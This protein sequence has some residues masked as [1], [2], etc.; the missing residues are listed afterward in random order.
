MRSQR[1]LRMLMYACAIKDAHKVAMNVRTKGLRGA[2]FS[3]L[4]K[5]EQHKMEK[6]C[7]IKTFPMGKLCRSYYIFVL[8]P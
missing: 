3:K 4:T 8:L 1:A 5:D 6:E 7:K 2:T